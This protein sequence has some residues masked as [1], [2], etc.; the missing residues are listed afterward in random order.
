MRGTKAVE[1]NWRNVIKPGTKL[2]RRHKIVKRK[3]ELSN[4]ALRKDFPIIEKSLKFT[5]PFHKI[6]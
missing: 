4:I 2:G 5:V 1:R 6:T 3:K